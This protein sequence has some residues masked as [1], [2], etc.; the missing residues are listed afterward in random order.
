MPHLGERY[1]P[2]GCHP[3]PL[4]QAWLHGLHLVALDPWRARVL[5]RCSGG[6]V[7]QYRSPPDS[8]RS[9]WPLLWFLGRLS[10]ESGI[11]CKAK[12]EPFVRTNLNDSM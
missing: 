11:V 4:A 2:S 7:C 12:V 10:S 6:D 5:K 9:P 3:Q 8:K 1:S